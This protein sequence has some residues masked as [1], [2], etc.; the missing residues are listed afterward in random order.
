MPIS[1]GSRLSPAHFKLRIGQHVKGLFVIR[2][3]PE[4]GYQRKFFRLAP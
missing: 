4:R 3:L 1:S 2:N